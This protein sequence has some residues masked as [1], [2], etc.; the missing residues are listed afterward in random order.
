[1]ATNTHPFI[2]VVGLC[3]ALALAGC[4][5]APRTVEPV[6]SAEL[7]LID[8]VEIFY[9]P[10]HHFVA[11]DFGNDTRSYIGGFSGALGAVGVLA[12]LVVT[13][14]ASKAAADQIPIRT[15]EFNLAV[16][17][18]SP[19]QD[20]NRDFAQQLAEQLRGSG[21]LVKL[22]EVPRLPG[23]RP[24]LTASPET[25]VARMPAGGPTGSSGA[26][27]RE[28]PAPVPQA[29]QIP[30]AAGIGYTAT[31]GFAPLLLRVTTGYVSRESYEDYKPM[32]VV[33]YALVHPISGQYLADGM[34]TAAKSP[35]NPDYPNWEQLRTQAGPA[36]AHLRNAL[37]SVQGRV[38]P[39]L[40]APAR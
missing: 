13:A 30:P 1:M 5:T 17:G 26:T 36:R 37:L 16:K 32:A 34:L 29:P 23:A 14:V 35:R 20:M 39:E 38:L 28:V 18:E 2:F 7:R 27:V 31:P 22:T 33:E 11:Q 15:R 8:K 19:D 3:S 24:G 21:R 12:T 40:A 6:S 25:P 10:E 4:A 9:S